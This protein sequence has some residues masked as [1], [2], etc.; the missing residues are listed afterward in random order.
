MSIQTQTSFSKKVEEPQ[1]HLVSIVNDGYVSWEFSVRVL[2]DIFYRNQEDAY[3]IADEIVHNGEG[4]CG[5]YIFEIAE[6]KAEMVEEL[7]KKENFS[8][9]C[10]IEE[11]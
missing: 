5:A 8:L 3:A 10:L 6:T 7:A 4:L 2:M 9:Y 11:V 1:V